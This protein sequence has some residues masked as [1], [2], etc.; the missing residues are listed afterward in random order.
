M[1][2]VISHPLLLSLR[3]RTSYIN[4]TVQI[5]KNFTHKTFEDKQQ[6]TYHTWKTSYNRLMMDS[7]DQLTLPFDPEVIWDEK[8]K[9]LVKK[10]YNKKKRK[11]RYIAD[12]RAGLLCLFRDVNQH[13]NPEAHQEGPRASKEQTMATMHLAIGRVT[14]DAWDFNSNHK[15]V[16][17]ITTDVLDLSRDYTSLKEVNNQFSFFWVK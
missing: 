3:Q 11:A 14:L 4:E 15:E 8:M 7:P 2:D 5:M 6:G 17:N 9:K 16:E 10:A 12:G 1:E 13:L